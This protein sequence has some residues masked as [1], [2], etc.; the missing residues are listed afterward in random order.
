MSIFKAL[1]NRFCGYEGIVPQGTITEA[2]M[3]ECGYGGIVPQKTIK[4]A[5]MNELKFGHRVIA[6]VGSS[7]KAYKGKYICETAYPSGKKPLIIE[8][9]MDYA[10]EFDYVELDPNAKEFLSGDQ[11]EV[12]DENTNWQSGMY[13]GCANGSA[14]P[15]FVTTG[16]GHTEAFKYCRYPQ[17]TKE[18]SRIV[19]DEEGNKY[20]ITQIE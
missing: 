11:V 14:C 17:K 12:R 16:E 10:I 1:Y 20:K 18:S 13:I 15:H 2:T 3:N 9:S 8:D 7:L 19:T 6:G 4:E 5:T